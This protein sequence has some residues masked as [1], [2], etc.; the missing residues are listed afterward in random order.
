VLSSGIQDITNTLLE[1]FKLNDV[2]H[3]ILETM[4][5]ALNC[6]RVIF[7][8]RDP[9]TGTLIGRMGIG[10]GVEPARAI[11]Q[12]PMQPRPGV[13]PDLFTL[14]CLKN[15][16][17][18]IADAAAPNIAPRLPA[19]FKGAVA[20]QTFLLLPL[21]LKRK[22]QADMVLGLIYADRAEANSMAVGERELSLLRTLRN[23]AIMA[24]KQTTGG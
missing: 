19:W 15:A 9:R 24:F 18:L 17:M 23:Q 10:E 8:L 6:R 13:T 16:D 22:G 7:C 2:L 14:V 5:R 20:A 4:L 1:T 11:F 12:V 21:T 3:M